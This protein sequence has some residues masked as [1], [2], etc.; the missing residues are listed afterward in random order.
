MTIWIYGDVALDNYEYELPGDFAKAYQ[1]GLGLSQ[2]PYPGLGGRIRNRFVVRKFGGA[3]LL[4]RYIAIAVATWNKGEPGNKTEFDANTTDKGLHELRPWA[5]YRETLQK[6]QDDLAENPTDFE[7]ILNLFY[8]VSKDSD[9]AYRMQPS[10]YEGYTLPMR[11]HT[12][13]ELFRVF[14]GLAAA[15]MVRERLSKVRSSSTML[16]MRPLCVCSTMAVRDCGMKIRAGWTPSRG[17]SSP[18]DAGQS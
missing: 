15:I 7:D 16:T 11:R 9:K 13:Q 18:I 8:R 3:H 14:S 10:G 4:A 2:H 17:L 6:M 5:E 1:E 12:D